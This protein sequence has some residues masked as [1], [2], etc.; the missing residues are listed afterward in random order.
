MLE[1]TN[2]S[3]QLLTEVKTS[4]VTQMRHFSIIQRSNVPLE[5]SPFAELGVRNNSSHIFIWSLLQPVGIELEKIWMDKSRL[6]LVYK[7]QVTEVFWLIEYKILFFR[8]NWLVTGKLAE[9]A[10]KQGYEFGI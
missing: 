9:S 3:P 10:G 7:Q 2:G 8:Q 6:D 4:K 1:V 5:R